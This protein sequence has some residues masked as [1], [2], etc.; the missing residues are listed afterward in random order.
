MSYT[1]TTWVN[2]SSPYID[3]DNLN[4]IENGI[5]TNEN[6]F[7]YSTNEIEIGKWIDDKPIY[8]KVYNINSLPNTTTMDINISTWNINTITSLGGYTSTGLIFNGNRDNVSSEIDLYANVIEN[9]ITI[10]THSDRSSMSGFVIV[11]YTKTT[12]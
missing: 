4:N 9:K 5:E 6:K 12:D 2:N 10:T 11:E 3:A 8:R 1:K 7:N